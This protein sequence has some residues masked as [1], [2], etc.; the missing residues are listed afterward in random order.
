MKNVNIEE[1]A[2]L[3]MSIVE[4]ENIINVHDFA[5]LKM[6]EWEIEDKE[7]REAILNKLDT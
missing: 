6:I 5:E 1:S 2:N 4:N 7:I 3:I